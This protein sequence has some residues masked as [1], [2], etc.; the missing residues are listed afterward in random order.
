MEELAP[1][2]AEELARDIEIQCAAMRARKDVGWTR[3]AEFFG[4][5]LA[6]R[7]MRAGIRVYRCPGLQPATSDQC[8]G[9]HSEKTEP[10]S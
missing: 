5:T 6:A 1:M 10:A 3:T 9:N 8:P 7:L 4:K 2:S